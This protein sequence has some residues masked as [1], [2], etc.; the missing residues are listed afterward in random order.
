MCVAAPAP[1]VVVVECSAGVPGS[2]RGTG[3]EVGAGGGG[4]GRAGRGRGHGLK[5][6]LPGRRRAVGPEEGNLGQEQ[7]QARFVGQAVR[8]VHHHAAKGHGRGRRIHILRVAW[9]VVAAT[10]AASAAAEA[11]A[12]VEMVSLLMLLLPRS[13]LEEEV[14]EEQVRLFH[15]AH[16]HLKGQQGETGDDVEGGEPSDGKK[17]R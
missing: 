4:V 16:Q 15:R 11:P 12:V 8:L 3:R 7:L 2:V 6:R 5:R 10:T 1:V 14:V 13:G 17:V 9:T